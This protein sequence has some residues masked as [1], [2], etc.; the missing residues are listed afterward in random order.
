M[1]KKRMTLKEFKQIFADAGFD[2]E[3]WGYEGILNMISGYTRHLA[4]NAKAL[5]CETAYDR[6]R[7]QAQKI[8]DALYERGYYDI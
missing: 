4:D 2:M 3:I 6:Q 8:F 5:G 1:S 7:E